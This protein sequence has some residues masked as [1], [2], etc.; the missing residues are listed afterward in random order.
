M[1]PHEGP[2]SD[3]VPKVVS[4]NL[5]YERRSNLKMFF[6]VCAR[7]LSQRM[8]RA[9][10][11]TTSMLPPAS[12][13]GLGIEP[14]ITRSLLITTAACGVTT[15]VATWLFQFFDAANLLALYM[16]T[17]VVISLKL[18]RAAAIWAAL[19]SVVCFDF[20]FIPPRLSFAVS[21]TQYLF[22]FTLILVIALVTSEV[23]TRLRVD[24]R[25]ARA[26]ERREATV[27]RV[28]R[29][30][31]GALKPEQIGKIC[32]ETIAP[33]F[34]A[35]VA[36][37]LPDL[38]DRLYTSGPRGFEDLSVAQWTYDHV[39]RA[40][41]GTNTLSTAQAL[42]VPLKAPIRCRGAVAIQ[43]RD[44]SA[45]EEPD[46]KRLLEACCASIAVALER[47][48]FA[49]V[50]QETLVRMEGERLRNSLLAAVS[51]DLRTPLTAIRGLAETLEYGTELS[52]DERTEIASAIRNQAEGL[53]RVITNLLD[54]ARMQ[55]AGIHLN[56]EWHSLDEIVGSALS[57][58][59]PALG[60][61]EIRT[62]LPPDLPLLEVDASL[63]ERVLVNLLDNALKYTPANTSILIGA[64][65]FGQSMYCFVEDR[66][67]G[68]PS[69]NPEHFF[70]PFVRG[71]KES[72][73]S[74]VGLGL[75]LSRNIVEAHGGTIRAEA[76]QPTGTRFEIR[77]PLG[78]PPPFEEEDAA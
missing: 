52:P 72:A 22:T 34:E 6:G 3:H 50:A 78:P 57:R 2:D 20:F 29:D 43:P 18:G 64:E 25:N 44:W 73:I 30:L 48:H 42:Y 68:L 61:R 23:G 7:E 40:G 47:I 37:I 19:L 70:E 41:R 66:G 56:K 46:G 39:Q 63:I 38:H 12:R 59:G 51:H 11:K 75:A 60:A 54:L 15:I 14:V 5:T 24:A 33:L 69:G 67:P 26:G 35:K 77:L 62:D 21:D 31:S 10:P 65:A 9:S 45:L 74:G 32:A 4:K 49:E 36:L 1:Q 55:S 17:V 27:A 76:A 8:A 58:L 71:Q 28:A 13:F 53:Q 16:L